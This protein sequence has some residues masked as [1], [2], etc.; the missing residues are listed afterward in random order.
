M[1]PSPPPPRRAALLPL[2]LLSSL[3]LLSAVAHA[4]RES[5]A[6]AK[7]RGHAELRSQHGE[8]RRAS[9]IYVCSMPR[10]CVFDRS[11]A[12]VYAWR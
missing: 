7:S 6:A 1:A 12:A 9:S 11:R 3:L 2:L 10:S 8:V 5:A 4:A